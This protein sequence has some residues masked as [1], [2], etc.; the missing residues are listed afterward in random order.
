ML[1]MHLLGTGG[2]KQ[3]SHLLKYDSTLGTFNADIK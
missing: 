2:V 3:A 1:N